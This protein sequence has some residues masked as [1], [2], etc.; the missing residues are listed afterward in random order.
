M[1]LGGLTSPGRL[2][3]LT[4]QGRVEGSRPDAEG[5]LE[6]LTAAGDAEMV[7]T[8]R[9]AR[10]SGTGCWVVEKVESMDGVSSD[11]M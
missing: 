1:A 10:L 4:V 3:E 9:R 8:V 6:R 2:E 7:L 5:D 11:N